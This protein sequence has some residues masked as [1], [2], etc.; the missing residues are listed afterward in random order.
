MT[1]SAR[2]G[3][4]VRE[5]SSIARATAHEGLVTAWERR[6][7]YQAVSISVAE[8]VAVGRVGRHLKLAAVEDHVQRELELRPV[9]PDRAQGPATA[10][11]LLNP[12]T[13]RV[14]SRAERPGEGGHLL[15]GARNQRLE[16]ARQD[17]GVGLGVRDPHHP[18]EAL[19]DHVVERELGGLD[20]VAAED[21]AESKIGAP[22]SVKV[23]VERRRDQLRP[24]QRG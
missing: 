18:D 17:R 23:A 14:A 3:A 12:R 2:G 11:E 6:A 15:A 10:R 4:E 19:A 7:G 9:R 22:R 1:S 24:A 21:R 16:G 5:R 13:E 20:R 8:L